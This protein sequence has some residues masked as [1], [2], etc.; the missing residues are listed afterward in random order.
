VTLLDGFGFLSSEKLDLFPLYFG[1]QVPL[2][3]VVVANLKMKRTNEYEKP[4][5]VKGRPE[6]MAD[7]LGAM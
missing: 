4:S 5:C 1:L 3:Q 7:S 6:P 2:A